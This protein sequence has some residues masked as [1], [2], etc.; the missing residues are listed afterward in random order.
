MST[1][2]DLLQ[3]RGFID[4]V[5][6]ESEL[7][8]YLNSNKV[9]CY[10]GFDP[11]AS[12]LHVGS[13]VCIMALAHMQKM[14]HR[15][16]ALV[17]GGTG[18]I[19][20]PS[21]KTEMRKVITQEQ[22]DVNKEGIKKQLSR[23]I[24]FSGGNA[25]L[26][27]N[28]DWLKG[29]EYIS[30]LRDI[31]RHFS[32]NRMIKAESYR[33]RIESEEGLSF[34][35]FN[36]MLLQ[37]YDFMKLCDQHDCM[38]QMGGSDQWGNIV[39]GIDLVRRTLQKTVF[40]I[41]FPLITTSSG[42]KMGKTHKGAVWLDP[43]RTS[44]YDYYQF[45]INSDDADVAR[46]LA[47]FTFIPMDEIKAVEKLE[48]A[49]INAAKTIL[50]FEATSIAHGQEEA[51]KAYEATASVFGTPLLSKG[52]MP[53]SV[54]P[55]SGDNNKASSEDKNIPTSEYSFELLDQGVA[56]VD[57]FVT[58]GLCNSKGEARR[59]ISQGGG[60]LNGERISVFDQKISLSDMKDG[61]IILRAGK[62]KF[63][64]IIQST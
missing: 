33:M 15:P 13:L 16:I 34:I 7:Q 23:F 41:T 38:V 24:D 60:Y 29:L 61:E 11:T 2:L 49:D 9:T 63:H 22:I 37:A 5:T 62:K 25:L 35:E 10:I 32:V 58:A 8:E 28:A 21:G 17:G 40:G 26:L 51:L 20:D 64:R 52:L 50:A 3:E 53:T 39:A 44:P 42:I 19:G 48:G 36:Y 18:L 14:G 43:E 4:A 45:W 12:S 47:L 1:I 56:V 59:L 54:I 31:G 57:V 46:F 6:H 27:D 30:F 55:R